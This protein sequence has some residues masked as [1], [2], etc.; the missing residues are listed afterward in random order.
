MQ[1]LVDFGD[2]RGNLFSYR[3]YYESD[4]IFSFPRDQGLEKTGRFLSRQLFLGKV[5]QLTIM[6]NEKA[7]NK[8][9]MNDSA[10]DTSHLSP[11][12]YN[13]CFLKGTEPPF[14]GKY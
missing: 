10:P 6:E 4:C 2:F 8:T 11:E 3:I 13:I 1:E 7:T 14:S 5:R 12:Q 9:L